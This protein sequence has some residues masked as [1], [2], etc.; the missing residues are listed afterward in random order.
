MIDTRSGPCI[1]GPLNGLYRESKSMMFDVV[2]H[3]HDSPFEDLNGTRRG[4]YQWNKFGAF[5]D[6]KGWDKK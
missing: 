4:V 2:E 3:L 1:D 6:W 5:W